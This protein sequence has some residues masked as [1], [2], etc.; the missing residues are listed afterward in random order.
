MSVQDETKA[1][2]IPGCWRDASEAHIR[3]D[4][5]PAGNEASSQEDKRMSLI[6]NAI[7]NR[8]T[9]LCPTV[10]NARRRLSSPP[11]N[12]SDSAFCGT[13]L[14]S[15]PHSRRMSTHRKGT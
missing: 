6:L 5:Q 14:D 15:T 7:W 9:W 10:Q 1:R 8:H 4:L 3:G 11:S 13:S 2:W 12:S